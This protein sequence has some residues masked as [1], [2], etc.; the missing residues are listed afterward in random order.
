MN[1]LEKRL[2]KV[3]NKVFERRDVIVEGELYLR[4][5]YVHF[6]DDLRVFLHYIGKSDDTRV[7]H[8]HPWDFRTVVLARGYR[9]HL[10]GGRTRRVGPLRTLKLAAEHVH[11]VSPAWGPAWTLVLAKPA[12]RVWGFHTKQGWQD[13]RTYLDEPDEKEW[14]EDM[15]TLPYWS[16]PWAERAHLAAKRN[17]DGLDAQESALLRHF[18]IRCRN[19]LEQAG[20]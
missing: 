13:W 8:D 4:R 9:E 7:L 20:A 11:A 14:P 16:S 15:V 18:E 10:P 17:R 5:W 12:R 6:G 2:H 3:L 19:A 1:W